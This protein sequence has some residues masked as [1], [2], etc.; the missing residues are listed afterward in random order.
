MSGWAGIDD[1][2]LKHDTGWVQGY[3]NDIDTLLVFESLFFSLC[4]SVL[5][6]FEQGRSLLCGAFRLRGADVQ[7]AQPTV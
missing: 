5:T 4:M 3:A 6:R 1:H 7:H 2:L